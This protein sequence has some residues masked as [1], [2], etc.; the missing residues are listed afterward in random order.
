MSRKQSDKSIK[1]AIFLT[2]RRWIALTSLEWIL[3][4]VTSWF[5]LKFV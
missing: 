3:L 1:S 2:K 5:H 4:R